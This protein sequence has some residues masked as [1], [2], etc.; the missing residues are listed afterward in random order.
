MMTASITALRI[1]RKMAVKMTIKQLIPKILLVTG[2]AVTIL[3]LAPSRVLSAPPGA[4][5][6]Q[7]KKQEHT[8]AYIEDGKT[9]GVRTRTEGPGGA[10]VTI[11]FTDGARDGLT[12]TFRLDSNDN[13]ISSTSKSRDGTIANT[14]YDGKGGST[15]TTTRPNGTVKTETFHTTGLPGADKLTSAS[16]KTTSPN[17]TVATQTIDPTTGK[18]T[19][20]TLKD[21]NGNVTAALPDGKGGFTSSVPGEHGKVATSSYDADGKLTGQTTKDKNG[22]VISS[23]TTTYD[24]KG[25]SKS[26]TTDKHGKVISSKVYDSSGNVVSQ[27]GKKQ[28]MS[29]GT[30]GQSTGGTQTSQGNGKPKDKHKLQAQVFQQNKDKSNVQDSGSSGAS[31]GSGQQRHHK[32]H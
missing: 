24:P 15:V 1:S 23:T 18:P 4:A 10:T 28:I 13:K 12:V 17:G 9:V 20:L 6:S 26:V 2:L 21:K 8:E 29:L 14:V 11:K 25:G 22:K 19:G 32:R 5:E 27:T 3:V 31:S 30:G 16:I 7:I